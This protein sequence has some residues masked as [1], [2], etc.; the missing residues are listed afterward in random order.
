MSH[1][2][3]VAPTNEVDT[4]APSAIVTVATLCFGGL[5]ASLMQ[6]LIVPIQPE[7]PHM[8]NTS[9][10]NASWIITATLLGGAVAMP[11]A[12]RLG[13][14]FGKRRVLIASA[15]LLVIGSL[16]CAIGDTLLPLVAG[17]T[18]QGLAM[19]FIPVGIS[20]M[21]E[22]T[23]P[24]LTSMAVAAMSATLGVG[25]AIGLPLAAW[26]SEKWDWHM[27][28][29]VSTVLAAVV[30]F[31]VVVFVPAVK[32]AVGGSLDII[33]AIGLAIGLV[34]ALIGITKGNDWGWTSPT[35]LGLILGGLV[36]LIAWGFY[37]LRTTDPLVDLR[38]T[39]RPA[40]LLTNLAG[41]AIGFGMMAQAIILPMLLEL[42]EST[43]YGL[44]QSI[45][46]A[47]L[48]MAP[49]GLMMMVFAPLS[50]IL[51]N[52]I[53]PK[54]TLAIGAAILGGGY[55]AAFFLMSAPW[56][57]MLSSIICSAGVGIGYA[58]MPTLVMNSVPA[59]EAGAAVG[60]NGLMRS[61]GTTI[62]SAV[63]ALLLT[64]STIEL[65]GIAFPDETAF[66]LCF[67]IASAAAFLGVLITLCIPSRRGDEPNEQ[68]FTFGEEQTAPAEVPATR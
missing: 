2:P 16:I 15:A 4:A 60:L 33:G 64:S 44:G 9:V 68:E 49:G 36:V 61:V 38:T 52:Q 11:I 40:V 17:R 47:G 53:G 28:F 67:I 58:A 32:D 35:T 20:L 46:H 13:D 10:S 37:Q 3:Q 57:L 18:I 21:R 6:T 8:L 63:M 14:M 42:P 19:G 31:A 45:L 30:L 65:S 26:I 23:P 50:G 62:A 24:K 66:R 41:A 59:S 56:Q 25:G 54:L 29:W 27:L 1:A 22:V 43:G 12:G 34:C 55:L 51:I 7:L 39:S 5:I 48:W